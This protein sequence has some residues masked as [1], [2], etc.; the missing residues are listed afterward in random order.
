MIDVEWRRRMGRLDGKVCLVTGGGSGIGRA[1]SELFMSEGARV[2]V[3]DRNGEAAEATRRSA[4]GFGAE[5]IAIR[6]DIGI[7]ADVDRMIDE[8]IAAWG[9]IDVLVNNSG[10]GIAGTVPETSEEDFAAL[11]NVNVTGVFRAWR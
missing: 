3:M 8:I 4:D 1:T 9:R 11:M 2:A 10:Y 6:A 5:A 7:T